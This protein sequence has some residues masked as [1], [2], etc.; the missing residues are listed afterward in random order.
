VRIHKLVSRGE[1]QRGRA[2]RRALANQRRLAAEHLA[3]DHR[4]AATARVEPGGERGGATA[5]DLRLQRAPAR[6]PVVA[7][8]RELRGRELRLG[9]AGAQ[10]DEPLLRPP[11]EVIERWMFR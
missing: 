3:E 6:E 7:R 1:V 9:I 10:L 4:V 5:I 2:I 11:L 8:D